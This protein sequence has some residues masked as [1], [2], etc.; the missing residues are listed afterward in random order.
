[1]YKMKVDPVTLEITGSIL[2]SIAREMGIALMRTA[3]S[4]IIREQRDFSAAIYDRNARAC[5]QDQ[6]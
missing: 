4:T 5:K 1:M 6:R 3:Y 2:E